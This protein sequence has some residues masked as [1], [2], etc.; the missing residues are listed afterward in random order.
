MHLGV[1]FKNSPVLKEIS[2]TVTCSEQLSGAELHDCI[3]QKL[4][5]EGVSGSLKLSI[6]GTGLQLPS[7]V[8]IGAVLRNFDWILAENFLRTI[9]QAAD[10]AQT[11]RS[12]C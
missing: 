9:I 6:Q 3:F 12:G 4:R 10:W 5:K 7:H 1:I 8:L 2:M 11:E